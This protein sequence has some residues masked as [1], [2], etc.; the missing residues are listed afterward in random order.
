LNAALSYFRL[1]EPNLAV[2]ELEMIENKSPQDFWHL[3][4]LCAEHIADKQS[5]L[6]SLAIK[7]AARKKSIRTLPIE[8]YKLMYP[9]RYTFTIQDQ[10]MVV[11]LCLAMIWQE[12]L[13][14]PQA[15]SWANARG[16]MQIIPPTAQQIA[17]DL[18]VEEYSLYDPSIS[19]RF[20]CFY[21][22]NLYREM[23]SIPFALAGYNAGPVR[24]KRWLAQ[25]PNY[26]LDVFIDLVPFNETRN[27]IKL[28]LARKKIY[29]RI[30]ML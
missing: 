17:A 5:I 27:Y 21:F 8:L 24:I 16:I 30:M 23:N 13:F 12:S 20:G 2:Y 3:S 15:R 1:H 25:D 4:R 19:I 29:E 9:V 18:G 11:P 28:I 14:D 6:Y 10:G 26:E 22:L 7:K